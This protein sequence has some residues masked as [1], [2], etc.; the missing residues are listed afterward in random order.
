MSSGYCVLVHSL[1]QMFHLYFPIR[2]YIANNDACGNKQTF[3]EVSMSTHNQFVDETRALISRAEKEARALGAAALEPDHFWLSLLSQPDEHWTEMLTSLKIERAKFY[4]DLHTHLKLDKQTLTE[5]KI[6]LSERSRIVIGRTVRLRDTALGV[7]I[8]PE[9]FLL[10]LWYEEQCQGVQM[11]QEAGLTLEVI[12]NILNLSVTELASLRLEEQEVSPAK[13]DKAS[14]R[15]KRRLD[16]A[17]RYYIPFAWLGWVVLVFTLLM[18]YLDAHVYTFLYWFIALVASKPFLIAQPRPE[19]FPWL[20]LGIV[21]SG[22]CLWYLLYLPLHWIYA[23]VLPR[24]VNKKMPRSLL[25]STLRWFAAYNLNHAF[26]LVQFL[27]SFEVVYALFSLFPSTWWLIS[28][29][30]FALFYLV[31][32]YVLS[33]FPVTLFTRLV[34]VTE[35]L[36]KERLSEL[37]KRTGLCIEGFYVREVKDARPGSTSLA[38]NAFLVQWGLRK[39]IVFTDAL[40]QKFPLDEQEV[41]LAHELGHLI[42]QDILQ[43]VGWKTLFVG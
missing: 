32:V 37:L 26:Q 21:I 33:R 27:I 13:P 3:I 38:A 40:Y 16:L 36:L 20:A 42:H 14:A 29:L 7:V 15:R 31:R 6:G 24:F 18:N 34:P 25:A 5:G 9:H 10:A 2:D 8:T 30:Y 17:R 35:G 12:S 22:Y 4:A 28:T 1:L 43:R 11:L 41:I 39:R 23:V 19:W